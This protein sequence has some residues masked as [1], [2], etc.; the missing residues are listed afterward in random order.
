MGAS[1]LCGLRETARS[2]EFRDVQTV[3]RY[4]YSVNPH[5][6]IHY[7]INIMIYM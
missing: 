7:I 6:P 1:E 4:V 5:L 2:I 3:T